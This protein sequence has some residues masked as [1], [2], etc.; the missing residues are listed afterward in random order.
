MSWTPSAIWHKSAP[1]GADES[2]KHGISIGSPTQSYHINP[3]QL[4]GAPGSGAEPSQA[5]AV[6]HH[7]GRGS[8]FTAFSWHSSRETLNT[9]NG[10]S[11]HGGKHESIN[12]HL[13]TAQNTGNEW[14]LALTGCN[15][16]PL[17]LLPTGTCCNAQGKQ[18]TMIQLCHV[19]PLITNRDHRTNWSNASQ[20]HPSFKQQRMWSQ[21]CAM[22]LERSSDQKPGVS[23]KNDV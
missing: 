1:P 3:G 15:E 10:F 18:Q 4:S 5:Q 9:A 2:A 23:N 13:P 11:W 6:L 16:F 22:R 20:S 8:L 21:G 17:I 19:T 7:T 12:H 14:C